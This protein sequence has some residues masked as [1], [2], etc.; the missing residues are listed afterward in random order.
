MARLEVSP[1]A[2]ADLQDIL[3]FIARDN[4]DRALSFVNGIENACH[5][6]AETPHAG[7]DRSDLHDGLRSFPHGA[8]VVFYRPLPDG[9]LVVRVVHAARDI[10]RLF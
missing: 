10:A 6:W 1:V 4:P 7:R 9:L 3:V 5:T 8:Y 2:V